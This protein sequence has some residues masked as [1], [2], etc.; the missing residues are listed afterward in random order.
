VFVPLRLFALTLGAVVALSGSAQAAVLYTNFGPGNAYDQFT[1]H[2]VGDVGGGITFGHADSFTVSS[3]AQ[4]G[5]L[6]MALSNFSGANSVTVQLR[7]GTPAGAL[8]EMFTFSGLPAFG[9][10]G[11]SPVTVN[12]LVNP[13]LTTG[14]TYWLTATSTG[15]N[16]WNF[17]STGVILPHGFSLN[18]GAFD[19]SVPDTQGAFSV[20]SLDAQATVPE[21]ASFVVLSV[22]G[23][24]LAGR[25]RRRQ[26]LAA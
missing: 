16:A 21:P 3:N 20:N 26:A 15:L 11:N 25:F 8:L 19:T 13:N 2:T 4:L 23:L 6:T 5:S 12:S 14:T 1:G 17:N 10:S 22:A 18:G 24:C 7:S 9:A